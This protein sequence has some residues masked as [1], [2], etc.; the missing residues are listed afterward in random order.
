MVI[1]FH[2]L[3]SAHCESGVTAS[4]LQHY[5]LDIDE[6]L[7]FGIGSGLFFAYLPFIKLDGIPL[8]AFRMIPGTIFNRV[9]RLLGVKVK[10]RRFR[11][12]QKARA[13]LDRALEENIPV[14]L[15]V[16]VYWLPFFPDALRFHFNGHNLIAYGQEKGEYA[17]SDPTLDRPVTIS[18]RS[19]QKARFA[20]GA[21]APKGKMYYLTGCSSRSHSRTSA[22]FCGK[23]VAVD[24]AIVKG[25]RRTCF[26]MLKAPRPFGGVHGIRYLA[27]QIVSWPERLGEKK[28]I[29]YL[30][31]VIRM[32]EEIGTGGAGFRFIYGAFLQRAAE[33]L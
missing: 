3:Q 28:A 32:Q 23:E 2:H 17:I 27:R 33:F 21:F 8:T 31:Q 14:G 19:L 18:L 26:L 12:P 4:L 30:A 10:V 5:G 16:G 9:T 29:L 15:Q 6:P 20:R 25:I 22:S 11:D 1:D 13:A 7:A 24:R